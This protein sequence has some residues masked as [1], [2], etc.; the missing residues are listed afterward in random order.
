MTELPLQLGLRFFLVNVVPT[1][2]ATAFVLV[3]IR[4]GAPGDHLVFADAWRSAARL[5]I[6]RTALLGLAVL[7]AAVALHPLQVALVRLYEGYWPRL[8][9][10]PARLLSGRQRHHMG[11]V[12]GEVSR[13]LSA[14]DAQAAGEAGEVLRSSFPDRRAVLPTRLGNTLAATEERAGAV[15]GWDAAVAWP[16]LYPVLGDACRQQVDDH[17]NS[18]DSGV[19]LAAT[20]TLLT[21]ATVWLLWGSGWW[22]LLAMAPSA[23]AW[24]S[25]RGAVQAALGYGQAVTAAFDLHRFDLL[26]ALHLPLPADRDAERALATELCTMWRQGA[27]VALRYDHAL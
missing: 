13:A 11:R 7:V 26:T 24:I 12:A 22:L 23:L 19:R 9:R 8:L 15:Y 27:P 4:A 17:R 6:G 20:G 14:Q 21:P 3:L 25:Y 1:A 5:S 10:G 2:A 18:L 16:R